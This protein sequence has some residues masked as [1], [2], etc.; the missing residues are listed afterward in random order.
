MMEKITHNSGF[1]YF[2][3]VVK[4]SIIEFFLNKEIEKILLKTK[5]ILI[6]DGKKKT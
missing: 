3:N 2:F 5:E 4:Q 1:S 6:E